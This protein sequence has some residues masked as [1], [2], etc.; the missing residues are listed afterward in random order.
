M[1]AKILLIIGCALVLSACATDESPPATIDGSAVSNAIEIPFVAQ[2]TSVADESTLPD[3]I[4][5]ITLGNNLCVH[6]RPQALVRSG[7]FGLRTVRETATLSVGEAQVPTSFWGDGTAVHTY[8][9]FGNHI[10][11]HAGAVALCSQSPLTQGTHTIVF[12]ARVSTGE[13]LTYSWQLEI[14]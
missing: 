13:T 4:S 6:L 5:K 3:F 7:D 1:N 9:N 10:G 12:E 14:P 2:S 11:S 8:D